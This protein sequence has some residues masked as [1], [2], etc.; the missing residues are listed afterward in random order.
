MKELLNNKKQLNLICSL[1][2]KTKALNEYLEDSLEE[3]LFVI[4]PEGGF[5]PKEEAYLIENDFKPTTL[6]KRVLR[7]ET[8]AIYVASI[9]NYV[10]KG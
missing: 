3:V 1:N 7:V 9:I 5:S 8:A 6:G 10:Y 4:G 2:D